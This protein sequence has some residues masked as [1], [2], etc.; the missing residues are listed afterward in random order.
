VRGATVERIPWPQ[1]EGVGAT[2]RLLGRAEDL[3][4]ADDDRLLQLPFERI[5][6]G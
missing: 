5:P 3:G 6:G 1:V 4:V 2:V